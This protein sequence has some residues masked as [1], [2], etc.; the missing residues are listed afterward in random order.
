MPALYLNSAQVRRVNLEGPAL[1]VICRRQAEQYFPLGRISRIISYGPVAWSSAALLECLRWRVPITW[2]DREGR[3]IG[4]CFGAWLQDSGFNAALDDFF[5]LAEGPQRLKDWFRSQ[6][7]KRLLA[8]LEHYDLEWNDLRVQAVRELL[9]LELKR[10]NLPQ[11][12]PLLRRL[13]L[14][15][16]AQVAEILAE[17]KI[18][19]SI[20]EPNH[21]WRGLTAYLTGLLEWEWWELALAGKLKVASLDPQAVIACYEQHAPLIAKQARYWIGQ[22]WRW[23]EH[24]EAYSA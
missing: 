15:T 23:L 9:A 14:L 20:C 2:L 18:Q 12:L 5:A 22:L 16:W 13:Y 3:L 7:R 21:D 19:P 11:S 4:M 17:F 10:R 6:G 8:L 24:S 1:K